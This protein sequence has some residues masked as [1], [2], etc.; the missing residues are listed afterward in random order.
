MIHI[1]R[2]IFIS[3]GKA[4]LIKALGIVLALILCALIIM[5]TTG[6]NPVSIFAAMI[7]GSFGSTRK[8]WNFLQSTAI[9]LIISLAVTPAFRMRCWNLGAEGQVLAGSLASAACMICLADKVAPALLLVLMVIFSILAGAVWAAIPALFKSKWN[10]N[11][12]LFTLMMNYVAIQL[13]A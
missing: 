1:T 9:L 12:T 4:I 13:V 8:M 7:K 10:T 2:R 11:E 6:D 3:K 5:S